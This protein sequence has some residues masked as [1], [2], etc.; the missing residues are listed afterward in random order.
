LTSKSEGFDTFREFG[1]SMQQTKVY[2]ILCK[3]EKATVNTIAKTAQIDR[4]EVYRVIPVLHRLGLVTEIIDSP[5][6][7]RATP[8]EEAFKILL[9]QDLR[10][11]EEKRRRAKH[12]LLKFNH[13]NNQETSREDTQYRLKKGLI[14]EEKE[15]L[16]ELRNLQTSKDGIT[17]WT[18]FPIFINRH[19]E[20]NK[21]A[22]ERGVK[23]RNITNIPKNAKIPKEIRA[24]MKIGCFEIRCAPV[25]PR[26]SVDIHDKKSAHII[27]YKQGN[28]KKIQVLRINDIDIVDLL[29]DYF[30]LKWQS[31][32]TLDSTRK[33]SK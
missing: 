11:Y 25:S 1:I 5:I 8:P 10:K 15:L 24:L 23:M 26:A 9:E 27:A 29:K 16:K 17:D 7:Y 31:A 18:Y 28:I 12:F 20:V 30:E 33:T 13:N 19:F 22:L 21:E 4:A 2:L 6:A 32:T 14:S 3:F